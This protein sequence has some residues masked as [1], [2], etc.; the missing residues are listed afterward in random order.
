MNP[1]YAHRVVSA[2]ASEIR[3]LLKLTE[4]PDVISF[5][6]ELPAPELFPLDGL[7]EVCARALKEDGQQALQYA[8]TE[9]Y[10]PLR[11]WIARRMRAM[12]G[13]CCPQRPDSRI[14]RAGCLLGSLFRRV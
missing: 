7:S 11:G 4:Q 1:A 14:L 12:F 6:G 3:E 5:A 9:G 8:T 2:K 13:V 10:Q